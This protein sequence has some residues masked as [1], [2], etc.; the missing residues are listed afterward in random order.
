M[1]KY[2]W[3]LVK[4]PNNTKK[5]YQVP[6]DVQHAIMIDI[7]NFNIYPYQT[8]RHTLVNVPTSKYTRKNGKSNVTI[9]TGYITRVKATTKKTR[10]SEQISRSQFIK[11][12]YNKYGLPKYKQMI[13]Y[14]R[15]DY[16][17]KN[18]LR[19]TYNILKMTPLKW[20]YIP[21]KTINIIKSKF[22]KGKK[23]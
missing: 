9:S 3:I 12:V 8:L 21:K 2:T 22:K 10:K 1:R 14:M 23:P 7:K 17:T 15:H 18:K 5:W 16:S 6:K 4:L 19:I 20:S 13:T 11:P